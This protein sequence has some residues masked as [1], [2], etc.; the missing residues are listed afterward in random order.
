[1]NRTRRFEFT[2]LAI[3]LLLQAIN[4]RPA[5]AAVAEGTGVFRAGLHATPRTP[6]TR[7]PIP[8]AATPQIVG[9]HDTDIAAWPW[10]VALIERDNAG[11]AVSLCGGTLVAPTIVLSAAHCF[12]DEN[13]GGFPSPEGRSI[14]A[15]RTLLSSNDGQEIPVS[16]Y[17]WFNDSNGQPL[18]DPYAGRWDVV[19]VVLEWPA[20]GAA[21]KIAGDGDVSAWT[22]G[23]TAFATGWGKLSEIGDISDRLQ[24]VD[25]EVQ[26]DTACS[27]VYG[28]FDSETMLCAGVLEGGKDTCQGDSGGPLVVPVGNEYRL[29]GDTSFGAGCARAGT[30]GVYGRLAADPMRSTLQAA[31]KNLAGV[32]IVSTS[33]STPSGNTP[34]ETTLAGAPRAKTFSTWATFTFESNRTDASFL[35]RLDG[36]SWAPCTSPWTYKVRRGWHRFDVMA[37]DAG[38]QQDASPATYYW[39]RKRR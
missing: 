30:P 8:T 2:A 22:P 16:T 6:A 19:I 23:R 9:G 31:I 4:G 10:Q 36:A 1:M 39:K 27:S 3:A 21:I 24:V 18:Y 17:Y 28:A 32:D 7:Q 29:I 5:G 13:L 20:P 11:S 34:P 38:G 15:G 33:T 37:V 25:L 14:I 12:Y 26:P 35:C